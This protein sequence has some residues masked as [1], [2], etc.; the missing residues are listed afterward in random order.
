M[1][2]LKFGKNVQHTVQNSVDQYIPRHSRIN[3]Y[4]DTVIQKHMTLK[5]TKLLKQPNNIFEMKEGN[6]V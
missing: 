2:K 5:R 3:I 6:Y 1:W 4:W